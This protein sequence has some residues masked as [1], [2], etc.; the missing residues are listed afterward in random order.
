MKEPI[1]ICT[2]TQAAVAALAANGTKSS[3][4][5]DCMKKLTVLPEVKQ[6]TIMWAPGHRGIHQNEIVERL[7][8]EG[9]RTRPI[10]PEPFL[11]LSLSRFKSKIRNRIEERKQTEWRVCEGYG[12][13]QLCPE[14]PTDMYV[15][16]ISKLD[17]KHCRMLVGFL[18]RHINLRICCTK[19]GEQRLFML[20]MRRRKGNVG[21]HSVWVLGVGKV[22]DADVKLCQ[23]GSGT[24]KRSEAEWDHSSW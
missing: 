4:V 3:L 24:N 12:I 23:D 7:A 20:E 9:P 21:T 10:G 11:P 19:W 22:K 18:T 15:Q 13:S 17:R 14:G 2:D 5:A 1:S 6:I 8:R 16:L